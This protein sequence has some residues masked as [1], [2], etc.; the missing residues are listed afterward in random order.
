MGCASTGHQIKATTSSEE[1]VEAEGTAPI[2][3]GDLN[4]AKNAALHDAEKN[5][6]GLVIGVY[7]SQDALVSKAL[8]IEDNITS[9]TEGYIEKI[10]VISES[11][12]D[13]FYKTKIRALV[14]KEDLSAK[15]KSLELEPKKLGN[16]VV[17]VSIKEFIDGKVSDTSFAENELKGDFTAMGFVVSDSTAGADIMVSGKDESSFSTDE[18]LGGMISYRAS[19]TVK[20]SK[21]GS[22]DVIA[23]NNETVGG[24]DSTNE[25][26]ARA[27]ITNGAKKVGAYLPADVMKYLRER[28]TVNL[29]LSN[30]ENINKLNDF[31]R[32]ARVINEVRDCFVRNYSYGTAVVD[33]DVKKGNASDIAKRLEQLTSFTVKV[34]SSSAFSIDA[35][36][37]NK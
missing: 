5:A 30:V 34:K 9:Q 20:T 3:K 32:S 36:L 33:I 17:Y 37:V 8:L 28:S 27:A 31:I 6:L 21:A 29:T 13:N 12:D 25:A 18:G 4:G 16:P 22:Q 24:I 35:E 14:K 10:D 1:V 19:L 15:L 26:A 23:A 2:V 11:H 7:V